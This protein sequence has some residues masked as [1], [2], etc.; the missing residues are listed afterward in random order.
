MP[1]KIIVT[2]EEKSPEAASTSVS[3]QERQSVSLNVSTVVALCAA[4]LLGCF[5]LPWMNVIFARPSGFDFAKEGGPY[6]AFWLLPFCCVVTFFAAL[7]KSSVRV[8]AQITGCLPFVILVFG[9]Y[10][11]GAGF[12]KFLEVGAYFGLVLGLGLLVITARLKE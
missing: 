10:Q 6:S 3:T 1:E 5:F 2:S 12:P 7:S 9:F 11:I 8:S 4:L